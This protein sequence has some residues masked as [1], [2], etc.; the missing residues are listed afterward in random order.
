MKKITLV[1]KVSAQ[2]KKNKR[3]KFHNEY[4]YLL[5]INIFDYLII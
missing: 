3:I 5:L 4:I 2:Q 1:R